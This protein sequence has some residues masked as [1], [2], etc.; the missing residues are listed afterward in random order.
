MQEVEVTQA[1]VLEY[2]AMASNTHLRLLESTEQ[3]IITTANMQGKLDAN[4]AMQEYVQWLVAHPAMIS[5]LC[6]SWS[7]QAEELKRW[8]CK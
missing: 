1:E 8:M 5:L 4:V 7:Q 2:F 3:K 6:L